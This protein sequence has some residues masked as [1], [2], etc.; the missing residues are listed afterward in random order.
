M[1]YISQI[2]ALIFSIAYIVTALWS[3]FSTRSE[4]Y[5]HG[6]IVPNLLVGAV[7]MW[8]AFKAGREHAANRKPRDDQDGGG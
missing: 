6:Y 8:I 5:Q 3:E 4:L 1:K 7:L 2:V